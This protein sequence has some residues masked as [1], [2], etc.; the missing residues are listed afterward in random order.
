MY[1]G[2]GVHLAHD[3][4]RNKVF[5]NIIVGNGNGVAIKYDA[6]G[7]IV[8]ENNLTSNAYG[9]NIGE[10]D[11][12]INNIGVPSGNIFY[13]NNFIDNVQSVYISE[14]VPQNFWNYGASGNFWSD[15]NGSTTEVGHFFGRF[16]VINDENIDYLPLTTPASIQL[17][18]DPE[19][20][21]TL[22][23]VVSIVSPE[24]DSSLTV[25]VALNFTINEPTSQI[26]YSLDGAENITISGNTTLAMLANS[27][28][29]LTVYAW[30]E[31]GNIGA[32]KTIIFSVAEPSQ[33]YP[34]TLVIIASGASLA[35][36]AAGVLVYFKKRK[37]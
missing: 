19:A 15:Y 33:S 21:D 36:V 16:Y 26:T 31:A 3:C 7:N 28:H 32:S 12:L 4:E 6:I 17:I 23:P 9:V 10:K 24:N 13:R 8:F 25:D 30:D 29:N 34:T 5:R 1:G 37:R 2:T 18:E 35:V 14:K 20:V 27:N 22:P 11:Y